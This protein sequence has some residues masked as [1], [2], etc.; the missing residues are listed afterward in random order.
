MLKFDFVLMIYKQL[1]YSNNFILN[2]YVGSIILLILKCKYCH[3]IKTYVNTNIIP[4][5]VNYYKYT[6]I[7]NSNFILQSCVY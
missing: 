5:S 1:F 6:Q 3:K 4:M 7:L 2:L